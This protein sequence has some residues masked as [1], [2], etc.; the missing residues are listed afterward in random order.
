MVSF[1]LSSDSSTLTGRKQFLLSEALGDIIDVEAR[2]LSLRPVLDDDEYLTIADLQ[3]SAP[4]VS[5]Q[6]SNGWQ[7]GSFCFQAYIE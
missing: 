6:Y 1:L 4:F 5:R 7:T 3:T 2:L